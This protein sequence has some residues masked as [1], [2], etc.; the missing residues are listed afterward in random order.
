MLPAA[1]QYQYI[2]IFLQMIQKGYCIKRL[3]ADYKAVK[4]YEYFGFQCKYLQAVINAPGYVCI[5]LQFFC[6]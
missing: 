3:A 4:N 1:M 2:K 5:A 6:L